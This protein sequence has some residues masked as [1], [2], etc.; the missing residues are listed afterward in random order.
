MEPLLTESCAERSEHPVS[1]QSL[2][3]LAGRSL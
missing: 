1:R 3:A 2:D